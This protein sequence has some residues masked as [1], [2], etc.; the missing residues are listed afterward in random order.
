MKKLLSL[1]MILLLATASAAGATQKR[2]MQI[3]KD[4]TTVTFED[5]SV[6]KVDPAAATRTFRWLIGDAVKIPDTKGDEWYRVPMGD[7]SA[8]QPVPGWRIK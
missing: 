1:V 6:Y 8:G 5:G 7:P 3:S 4:G 2:I